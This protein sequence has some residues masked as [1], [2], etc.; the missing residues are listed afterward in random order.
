MLMQSL[1]SIS[2][3]FSLLLSSYSILTYSILILLTRIPLLFF[4]KEK[5][6]FSREGG[7]LERDNNR[8]A[9][10]VLDSRRFEDRTN[11]AC[12]QSNFAW[13]KWRYYP[14]KSALYYKVRFLAS[15]TLY[16]QA[17]SYIYI[18]IY[19]YKTQRNGELKRERFARGIGE[20]RSANT[21]KRLTRF[22]S[23]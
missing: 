3:S 22:F 7:I 4:S 19:I 16:E 21:L 20:D 6:I 11:I 15:L 18:Y 17:T 9:R 1:L 10:R 13:F 8:N 12:L 14:N 2:L 23:R 5:N